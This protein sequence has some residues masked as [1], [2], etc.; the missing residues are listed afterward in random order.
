M[1]KIISNTSPCPISS[2]MQLIGGKW[3]MPIIYILLKETKRFKDLERSV[4]GINTRMLV[5]EL[6]QLEEAGIIN[7]QVF[8]EVPP[9]VEY[10]LTEK[11]RA[12]KS[13]LDEL[14]SWGT[15]YKK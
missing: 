5:K 1:A 7:R 4:E 8:A 11:G 15:S 6:K 14:K 12:L 2:T 3:S 9:R 13:V 10:S